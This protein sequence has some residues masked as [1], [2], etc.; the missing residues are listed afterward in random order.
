MTKS[1]LIEAV[2]ARVPHV[3]KK[4]VEAAVNAVFDSMIEALDREERIEIRGFGSF[5]V[6]RRGARQGRN[7]KTGE[8]VIVP[9]RRS[10]FFAVGKELR[11]RI[12][13]VEKLVASDEEAA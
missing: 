2:S 3:H 5:I 7:P 9:T 11:E 10:P 4:D 6:R 12:N 1:Q 13:A 8:Q